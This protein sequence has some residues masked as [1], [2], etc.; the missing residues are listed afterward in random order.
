MNPQSFAKFANVSHRQSFPPY[1]ILTK[2]KKLFNLQIF[3]LQIF[4]FVRFNN[5]LLK[6]VLE[7][8]KLKVFMA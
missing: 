3:N 6:L 7:N 8:S 5:Y 1:G 4:N 2:Y